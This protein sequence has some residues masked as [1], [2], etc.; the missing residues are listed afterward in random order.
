LNAQPHPSGAS[1]PPPPKGATVPNPNLPPLP[2]GLPAVFSFG[3]ANNDVSWMI[4]SG[5]PWQLRYQ[6]LAGGVNTG[7]GWA[8]WN[9]PPGQFALDYITAS[10][11]ANLIPVFIYY[12]I[13]QSGPNY[14]EY[15]NLNN[16]ATMRTYFADFKLLMQKC[17]QAGGPLFVDIEPDLTGV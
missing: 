14:S 12:Q 6:Y 2:A 8:T 5:I 10:R 3:L 1:A 4:G 16:A 9:S 11:A 17:A 7:N 15:S 13:L